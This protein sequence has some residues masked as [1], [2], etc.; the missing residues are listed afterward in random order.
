M[1]I[2]NDAIIILRVLEENGVMR[3]N[4]MKAGDILDRS[5]LGGERFDQ[6]DTYL[7][8]SNF[9][10]GTFGGL[11]G[12]R[13]LTATG[14]EY[15]EQ[16]MSKRLPL[17]LD[18]EKILAYIINSAPK[19]AATIRRS[20]IIEALML[21]DTRYASAVQNLI[22]FE[23]VQKGGGAAVINL[24]TGEGRRS[25]ESLRATQAGR[26]ALLRE[27][28]DPQ[29]GI[30]VSQV[31]NAPITAHNFQAVASAINSQIEQS[32]TEDD[33]EAIRKAI[34]EILSELVNQ[35]QG[36]LELTSRREYV[37]AATELEAELSRPDPEIE[38]IQKWL[39]RLTLLEKGITVTDK[40]LSLIV[41]A[42][43][44]A[45]LLTNNIEKLIA[46]LA[47]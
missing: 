41:K 45:M 19:P 7:M 29:A 11:E 4:S 24:G 13:W 32:I 40:T 27:F 23:L 5:G 25:E 3:G 43:P 38:N 33:P 39:A 47:N 30:Q 31:F 35:V 22:D 37:Q 21:D 16:V 10:I 9:V 18:A 36:E 8:E 26:Q 6:A 12:S 1:S 44:W 42:L 34:S 28:R 17:S 2:H 20:E 15:L 46:A 14:I